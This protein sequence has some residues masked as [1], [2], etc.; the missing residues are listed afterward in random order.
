MTRNQLK[1][2]IA[3][4]FPKVW[5]RDSEEF[6]GA[7]GAIWTGEG[8]EIDGIDAFNMYLEGFEFGVHPELAEFLESK[9][10]HAEA[11]DA[12][13]FFLYKN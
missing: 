9:D 13:T 3:K 12:G 2:A 4:K 10:W 1:A 6:N 7:S 11:Y 5:T 8:S